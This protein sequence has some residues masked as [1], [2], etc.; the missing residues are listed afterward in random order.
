MRFMV[1]PI[2]PSP[3]PQTARSLSGAVLVT[4]IGT[5]AIAPI[6]LTGCAAAVPAVALLSAGAGAAEA[7]HGV[8]EGSRLKIVDEVPFEVMNDAID[9]VAD[10]LLMRMA[11]EKI[12]TSGE[13]V[14]QRRVVRLYVD[15][16]KF[17]KVTVSRLTDE[18]TY[19]IINVGP[20]GNKAAARLF[21]DR[22]QAYTAHWND[23]PA[24]TLPTIDTPPVIDD[25]AAESEDL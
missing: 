25:P 19:V 9:S 20:F 2:A 16:G 13:P 14:P 21:A 18:L 6:A 12:S 4:A 10:D 7:G 24:I 5:A 15:D 8:W 22:V 1:T 23:D 3:R 11:G 17:S